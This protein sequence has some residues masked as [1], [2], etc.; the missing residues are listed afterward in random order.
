M[1][2]EPA[3]GLDRA[4]DEDL[5]A[6]QAGSDRKRLPVR[7]LAEG[8]GRP[9]GSGPGR[10]RPRGP[11]WKTNTTVRWK[12]GSPSCGMA[13]RNPGASVSTAATLPTRPPAGHR[14]PG[15]PAARRPAGRKRRRRGAPFG[16][17]RERY[18]WS[19]VV[20]LVLFSLG[21]LFAIYEASTRSATR[22]AR[23]AGWAF[24]DPR[25]RDRDGGLSF[26][27]AVQRERRGQGRRHLPQFIR[28]A[29]SPSSR[30]CCSR[31][32]AR[33]V[34]LV[35]A[36][37]AVSLPPITGDGV[38]GRLRHAPIGVLLGIVA[39]VLAIEMKSLLIGESASRNGSTRIQTA[40]ESEPTSSG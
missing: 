10:G 2:D 35:F 23:N 30:S 8:E 19:F 6:G 18:F 3:L 39:I 7:D 40:I 28:R 15:P 34:G 21:S 16:Y 31:T 14:Q 24:G 26:R 9:D 17:G 38:L 13:M 27:T 4:A 36:L 1:Q 37:A 32:S 5:L 12:F 33:C 20:A 22:D 29:K 25:V 11:C